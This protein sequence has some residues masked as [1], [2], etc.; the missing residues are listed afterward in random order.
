[1][2][3]E[4]PHAVREAQLTHVLRRLLATIDRAQVPNLHRSECPAYRVSWPEA[5]CPCGANEAEAEAREA[6]P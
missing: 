1:M 3:P 5:T 4:H 6:L 2:S